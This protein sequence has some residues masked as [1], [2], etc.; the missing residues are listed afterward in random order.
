MIE[1]EKLV[2]I[3]GAHNVSFDPATLDGYSRDVSFVNTV[4]PACVVKPRN[5]DQV[6]QL[7]I[8]ANETLTPLVSVSS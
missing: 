2:K 7:V 4:K 5:T 3:V 8:L 6:K 1:K